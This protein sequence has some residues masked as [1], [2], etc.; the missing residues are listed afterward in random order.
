M[1]HYA[2]F[3]L[4]EC[5]HAAG[6]KKAKQKGKDSTVLHAAVVLIVDIMSR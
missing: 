4:S 2:V 1:Q 3:S 5:A 6:A